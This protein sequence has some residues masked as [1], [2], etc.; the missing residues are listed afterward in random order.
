MEKYLYDMKDGEEVARLNPE[1]SKHIQNLKYE[2]YLKESGIPIDYWNLTYDDCGIG[3]NERVVTVCR[4]YINRIKTGTIKNLYLYGLNSTGKTTAMNCIGKDAIKEGFK[5]KFILSNDL[6][7]ILQKTSGY[8]INDEFERKK[9]ALFNA[10]LVLVDE[11]FDAS[12]STLWKGE[13]RN[14]I[15]SDLDGFFRHVISNNRRIVTTSNILK[16]RIASDYSPSLFELI[17]RNFQEL[18]FTESVKENRKRKLME[19]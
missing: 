10:D 8:G 14:L 6:I 13:S 12:K 1:W 2:F 7:N 15:V 9:N 18:K 19:N 3:S 11:V 4:N 5:V 16:E 17:D